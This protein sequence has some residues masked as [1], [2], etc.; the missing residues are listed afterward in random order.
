[1]WDNPAFRTRDR[2]GAT[3]RVPTVPGAASSK[4]PFMGLQLQEKKKWIPQATVTEAASMQ[5]HLLALL[6]ARPPKENR[7][8]CSVGL[9]DHL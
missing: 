1:M 8:T 5:V 6:P 2:V 9:Q 7:S 3:G 4:K